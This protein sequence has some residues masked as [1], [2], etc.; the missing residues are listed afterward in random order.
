MVAYFIREGGLLS[1][2]WKVMSAGPDRPDEEIARFGA[3]YFALR[4]LDSLKREEAAR[5]TTVDISTPEKKMAHF[6]HEVGKL[7]NSLGLDAETGAP[8]YLLADHVTQSM[9]IFATCYKAGLEIA[10]VVEDLQK[11]D[12]TAE[13]RQLTKAGLDLPA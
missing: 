6:T 7:I 4:Y 2:H 13:L 10:M 5:R 8:D 1:R 9:K 11:N 12:A 3:E